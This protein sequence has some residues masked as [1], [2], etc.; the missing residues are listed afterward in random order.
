MTVVNGWKFGDF[1]VS[2]WKF[3]NFVVSGKKLDDCGD[4]AGA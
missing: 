1:V 4:G 2:G 3:H